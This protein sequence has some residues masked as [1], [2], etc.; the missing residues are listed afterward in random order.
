M[1]VAITEP[2]AAALRRMSRKSNVVALPMAFD[3]ALFN[4]DVAAPRGD[5]MTVLT[6]G[7][8][9]YPPNRIAALK[10]FEQVVPE[11]AGVSRVCAF[12]SSVPRFRA[13]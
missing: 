3:E 8:F 4:P 11:V 9:A 1:T 5:D 13:I 12:A 10:L 7:N 6:V 2:D